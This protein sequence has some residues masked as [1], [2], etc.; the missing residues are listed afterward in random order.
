MREEEHHLEQINQ[1]L[2]QSGRLSSAQMGALRLVEQGAFD[3]LIH[4]VGVELNSAP[5]F[6]ESKSIN[7]QD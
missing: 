1:Q 4:A 5:L 3:N 7:N 2:L 6:E